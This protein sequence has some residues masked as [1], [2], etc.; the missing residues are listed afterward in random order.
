MSA[1]GYTLTVTPSTGTF[2]LGAAW[3]AP[4][5]SLDTSCCWDEGDRP[6]LYHASSLEDARRFGGRVF[7]HQF[8]EVK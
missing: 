1:N 3:A 7:N 8:E 2:N 6:S 4:F 5:F